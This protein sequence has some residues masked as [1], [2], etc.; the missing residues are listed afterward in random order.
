MHLERSLRLNHDL[1]EMAGTAFTLARFAELAAAQHHAVQALRL[2]GAAAT[3][4]DRLEM[5]LPPE[6]GRR[7]EERLEPA[8]RTMGPRAEAVFDAG[9]GLSVDAAVAE[10]LALDSE[11]AEQ[12]VDPLSPREREVVVL[13]GRGYT[14]RR[15]A[16]ELVIGEATVATHVQHILSKL[17]LASRTQIAVWAERQQ[18]SVGGANSV[19]GVEHATL[20]R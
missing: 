10:A 18:P 3:L 14:N 1:R 2:A 7:H 6:A 17:A 8:R 9:R 16:E 5:V 20:P 4:R 19:S 15:I 13:I 12:P 11:P